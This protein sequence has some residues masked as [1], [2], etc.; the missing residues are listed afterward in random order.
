MTVTAP[1]RRSA[2]TMDV[3]MSALHHTQVRYITKILT[4]VVFV[5]ECF[6]TVFV[7]GVSVKPG[8]CA[9]PQGTPMC[10]EYCYH[11]G[12]CPGEQKCCKTTCGHACSEPC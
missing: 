9:L 3:D 10:A 4:P 7:F 12:Q 1:M 8:R 2:A 6:V 5:C 11:D